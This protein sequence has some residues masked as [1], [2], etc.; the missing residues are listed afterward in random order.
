MER[1]KPEGVWGVRREEIGIL[2]GS[3]VVTDV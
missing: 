3:K 2:P 1:E